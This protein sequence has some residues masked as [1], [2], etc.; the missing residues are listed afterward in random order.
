MSRARIYRYLLSIVFILSLNFLIVQLLPGDPL[1]HLIGEEAYGQLQGCNPQAMAE[2]RAQYGL[3]KSLA[4]RYLVTL[5]DT[6]RFR[7]GWSYQY[8]KPVSELLGYRLKWTLLLLVP[9]VGLSAVFGLLLGGLAGRPGK[10]RLNRV[11]SALS[12]AI[13]ATP[14]YCL[15]FLLLLLLAFSSDVLPM[16]GM[17]GAAGSVRALDVLRHLAIPL[18]VLVLHNTAYLTIIMRG[19]VRQVFS[20]D[21]V[22]TAVAKGLKPRTVMFKHVLLNAL[23]PYIAAVAINFGFIA[24]GSLL[25]EVVFSWQGMGSLMYGAVLARD[26]PVLSGCFLVIA[27]AVVAANILADILVA[28]IDPRVRDEAA[29]A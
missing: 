22:L 2:L 18:T 17:T 3:D 27:L 13:Y 28:L 10:S 16:G 23:P 7:L 4:E 26:Y 11:I 24:G 1:V 25:V 19:A 20:E 12:L 8:G 14:A 15:A 29:S 5:A 9:A 21:Y 6:L